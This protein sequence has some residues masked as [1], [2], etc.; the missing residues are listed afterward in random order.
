ML[1]EQTPPRPDVPNIPRSL[2][3]I[4]ESRNEIVFEDP[5]IQHPVGNKHYE[6]NQEAQTYEEKGPSV[7][8]SPYV[9]Q[10]G[11]QSKAS[12]RLVL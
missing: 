12:K 9:T 8:K 7:S 5:T 3:R 6:S 11:R 10:S 4:E 1:E 2:Y